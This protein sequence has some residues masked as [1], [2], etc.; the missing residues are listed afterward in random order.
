MLLR[1]LLVCTLLFSAGFAL[2]EQVTL[3]N[4]DRITGSVAK[5]DDKTLVL[6]TELAGTIE[7]QWTAIKEL[8]SDKPLFVTTSKSPEPY[9]GTVTQKGESVE[10]TSTGGKMVS[11]PK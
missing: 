8:I 4:G 7:I 11:V 9:S 3:T 2:A 1:G 6:K 10:V 5:A